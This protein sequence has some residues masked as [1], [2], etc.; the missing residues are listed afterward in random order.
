M[1]PPVVALPCRLSLVWHCSLRS[2]PQKGMERSSTSF[3][4]SLHVV[5]HSNADVRKYSQS[6]ARSRGFRFQHHYSST[7]DSSPPP[8]P[9]RSPPSPGTDGLLP[10][11]GSTFL[12]S[13]VPTDASGGCGGLKG[14]RGW[15]GGEPGRL[16]SE[17]GWGGGGLRNGE[18]SQNTKLQN[19]I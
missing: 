1:I 7:Q 14:R 5:L 3:H 13:C 10:Y 4:H 17:G 16:W 18:L 11:T 6:A 2:R 8:Q 12:S 9:S 19:N 15:G